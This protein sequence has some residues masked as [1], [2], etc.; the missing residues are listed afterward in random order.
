VWEN[1]IKKTLIKIGRK[2]VHYS[3]FAETRQLPKQPKPRVAT[4][5][6]KEW[7]KHAVSSVYSLHSDA[8]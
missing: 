7:E 2:N 1:D 5:D 6:S 8:R 4:A 3:P